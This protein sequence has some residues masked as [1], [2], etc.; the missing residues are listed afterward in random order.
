[1]RK[2]E[3]GSEK[4]VGSFTGSAFEKPSLDTELGKSLVQRRNLA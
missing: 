2:E 1:M 4:R 3:D